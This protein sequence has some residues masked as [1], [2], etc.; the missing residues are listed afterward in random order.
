MEKIVEE[1]QTVKL[2]PKPNMEYLYKMDMIWLDYDGRTKKTQEDDGYDWL[3]LDVPTR[4]MV[5][6]TLKDK[7][8]HFTD[9]ISG[10]R[11]TTYYGWSLYENTEENIELLKQNA[12]V[13]DKMRKLASTQ[14]NIR[15][16]CVT[17]EK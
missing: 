7:R 13:L 10:I 6:V 17:L 3:G 4:V 11:Y 9:K 12:K 8:Y 5:D 14:H 15:S 16:K 1:K 2:E